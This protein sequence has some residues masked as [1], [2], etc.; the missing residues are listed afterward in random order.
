MSM[1]PYQALA[2]L[3]SQCQQLTAGLPQEVET[4]PRW[5]GLGFIL[6]GH[7]FVSPIGQISEMMEVPSSTRLPGVEP[8][9]IGLSNVRGRLL[10]LFDFALFLGGQLEQQKRYH[11]V[12]VL[13]TEQLFS[14][15][16]VEQALGMKDFDSA[17]FQSSTPEQLPEHV[18]PYVDGTYLD[19]DGKSWMVFDFLKL[20]ADQRFANA[21]L[22]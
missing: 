16:L 9:V 14:G 1:H 15:L 22:I 21:S 2:R 5:R 19:T 10:P 18:K 6:L 13:E 17:Q 4:A 20:A 7:A 3:S 11:R 12:F 8:W